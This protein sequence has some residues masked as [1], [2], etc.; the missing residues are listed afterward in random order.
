MNSIDL[1]S[2]AKVNLSLHVVAKRPDGYHELSMIMSRVS[3]Y[4]EIKLTLKENGVSL[5]CDDPSVPSGEGNI[6]WRAAAALIREKTLD[7]GVHIDIRKRIPMG[8]GLGGGSSNAATVLMGLNRLTGET[9][10]T[11]ELMNIGLDLGADVPFFIFQKPALAEGIGEK[12]KA[13]TGLPR[14]WLVLINPGIHVPTGE[15]FGRLNLGLTKMGKKL[16]ITR[17]HRNLSMVRSNM[18]N[19]LE[20]VTFEIYPEVREAKSLLVKY[21]AMA[22]LMSGSGSTVFGLYENRKKAENSLAA[23]G[24]DVVARGWSSY[25][26]NSL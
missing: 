7:R 11:E 2:P 14:L 5:N 16:N 3:L 4:D 19:D 18:T 6:A 23:M 1:L 15:I 17:F 8:G 10:G 13:V 22:A 26:V 20:N 24:G 25:L 12:L 9:A 21:G